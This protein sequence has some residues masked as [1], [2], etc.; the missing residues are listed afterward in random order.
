[1]DVV[2]LTSP[3]GYLNSLQGRLAQDKCEPRWEDWNGTSVLF[4]RRAA[5]PP[6]W[7]GRLH[8]FTVAA[9]F[10]EVTVA[11]VTAFGRTAQL[12]SENQKGGVLPPALGYVII[13]F[14]CLVSERVAPE[15]LAMAEAWRTVALGLETRPVV[16]DVTK[17]VVA[18]FRRTAFFGGAFAPFLRRKIQLYFDGALTPSAQA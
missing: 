12:Y 2:A 16:V 11:T 13:V 9:A 17:G 18:T 10:P 4:G 1:M 8:L 7:M 5:F 6:P 3:V 14:P 15:A